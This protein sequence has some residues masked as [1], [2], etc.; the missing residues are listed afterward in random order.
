MQ[1]APQY[2]LALNASTTKVIIQSGVTPEQ[3]V[4]IRSIT[5]GL[6]A[7]AWA[8]MANRSDL[9]VE[10]R[11]IPRLLLLGI[12]GVGTLQWAYSQAVVLLPVGIALLIEYTA[13]LWGANNCFA[14]FS[15][16]K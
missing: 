7:L 5:A 15:R 6:I 14:F 11:L 12:F 2:Y 3:A 8:L 1:P 4:F 10:K 16:K 13:V 9:R